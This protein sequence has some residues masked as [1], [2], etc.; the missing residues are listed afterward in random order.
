M[1]A[2]RQASCRS[3]DRSWTWSSRPASCPRSTTRSRCRRRAARTSATTRQ[4]GARGRAA[5]RREHRARDRHGLHRRPGARHGGGGHRAAD[6]G[7]GRQGDAR[8]HPQRHRRAGGRGRAGQGHQDAIPSTA[9][10]PPST[11]QATKVEMFETGIKVVDLLAP[12]R[13]GRQDR[14]LR[15]RRRRQDRAHPGADQ[16]HRQ[17]ARRLS[18]C[19]PASASARARATTS[20]SR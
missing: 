8:P 1:E 14:P 20:T 13:E 16:Q 15:R 17:A 7:A 5:P 11:E 18:R 9:R 3:S 19:S 6:L 10:R 2:R 12:Y 4:P